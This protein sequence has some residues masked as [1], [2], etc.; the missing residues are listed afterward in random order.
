MIHPAVFTDIIGNMVLVE[1]N[2]YAPLSLLVII[3]LS[4][5][6]NNLTRILSLRFFG[7]LAVIS[8]PVYIFQAPLHGI[9]LHF[10]GKYLDVQPEADFVFF[11]I[12]AMIA[13]EVL[14]KFEATAFKGLHNRSA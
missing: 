8:F 1:S 6:Q 2:W 13:A 14:N 7:I 9:Y 10:I 5:A 12:F 3:Y 11:L 4:T